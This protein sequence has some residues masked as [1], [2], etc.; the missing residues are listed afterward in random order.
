MKKTIIALIC[1]ILFITSLRAQPEKIPYL[2]DKP[3][4]FEILS[5]TNYSTY[6]KFTPTEMAA[7]MERIKELVS[8]VRKDPVLADIKGFMG[9]ARIYDIRNISLFILRKA[10]KLPKSDSF[11]AIKEKI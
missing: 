2:G 9:R 3:G 11:F 6:L 8:I 5:R 7:N 1:S 10:K 4:T